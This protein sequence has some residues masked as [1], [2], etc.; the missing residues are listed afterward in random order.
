MDSIYPKFVCPN[1]D[2]G[3]T[4]YAL[5]NPVECP[6]C[7]STLIIEDDEFDPNDGI[8]IALW[9]HSQRGRELD[10]EMWVDKGLKEFEEM[11]AGGSDGNQDKE[12]NLS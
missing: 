5:V 10:L 9:Y 6:S 4:T 12:E 2:C 3:L 11:L 7:G 8:P 1:E